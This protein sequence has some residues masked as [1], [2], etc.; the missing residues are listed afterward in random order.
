MTKLEKDKPDEFR[1]I[2]EPANVT[3]HCIFCKIGD[4]RVK[5]GGKVN[6]KE[7]IF[8]NDAIVAFD[9][10]NPGATSHSLVVPKS[11]IKNCWSITLELLD[12]MEKVADHILKERNP[13]GD[14]PTKMFFIR[15]PFNSVYHVH[16]HVMVL[17]LT[18]S[19]LNPRR[20]GFQSSWFHIT[21]EVL[22]HKLKSKQ[23]IE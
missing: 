7:L 9:D 8:E 12:K 5:P 23:C 1:Y 21:P 15:P 10:M 6:P 11:H 16:L 14:R 20:L 13:N 17:P 3:D 22:R 4:G 18:D 2:N 19:I